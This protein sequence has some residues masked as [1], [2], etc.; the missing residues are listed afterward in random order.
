[1]LLS[2]ALALL[3]E[4][5][6]KPFRFRSFILVAITLLISA[7]VSAPTQQTSHHN[8]SYNTSRSHSNDI[9]QRVRNGYAIP[10]LYNDEVANKENYY[11]Q[12]A[13]YV[14]RMTARSSEF[15]YLI[16]NEV[17]RRGMPSEIALLPFVESAFVTT[18]QSSAKATGLWQFMPATGRDFAL[19][20]NRFVD[21][22]NDVLASTDAALTFLQRLYNQFGDWQLA[23][24]A[25]NW[26]PG[27][28]SRA[29]RRAQANGL[30]GTY[31]DIQMP[32]ETRQYVPKLQAIKN[33]INNPAQYGIS[34]PDISNNL[35]Y[36]TVSVTRDMDVETAARLSGLDIESFKRINP[37]Y[38]K[39][40]IV[41]AL[42]PK[43][44]VPADRADDLRR[45]LRDNS[46]T[47]SNVTTYST[48]GLETLDDIAL[49]FNTNADNLRYLNNIPS[50]HN[51]VNA[52]STLLVPRTSNQYK[53]D[54]PYEALSAGLS[55]SG[56][57]DF[58]N[59]NYVEP[60]TYSAFNTNQTTRE[61]RSGIIYNNTLNDPRPAVTGLMV[62]NLAPAL[63]VNPTPTYIEPVVVVANPTPSTPPAVA[64][65]VIVAPTTPILANTVNP[66]PNLLA[67]NITDTPAVVAESSVLAPFIATVEDE[68]EVIEPLAPVKKVTVVKV[69][70]KN[71]TKVLSQ[72]VKV[73]NKTPVQTKLISTAVNN[74][75][76]ISVAGK[77]TSKN[78]VKVTDKPNN[79]P[80]VKV[81]DKSIANKKTPVTL[82]NKKIAK[83]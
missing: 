9:W 58:N 33:I 80:A 77:P 41:A 30:T 62:K 70:Q 7:C 32:A 13:D 51:N 74:K 3:K 65:E 78:A 17:E 64:P 47:L 54:I 61:E 57:T 11:A 20:Q 50:Y 56:G 16:M 81:V 27:N 8:T 82:S 29:I 55:T 43:I 24:A 31:A 4:S 37:A 45:A 48:Y 44:L 38:K 79:K 71:T 52:G 73:S 18:A 68:P 23:L 69:A 14:G 76:I 22:R 63:Q 19:H 34:L 2:H 40:V 59:G 6:F 67:V 66:L 12:R 25:Y 42:N 72:V 53:Q 5:M 60:A 36:E 1:M 46:Q 83:K 39:S 10:D 49:K 75:K 26:G 15:M 21:Q 28:V 35:R